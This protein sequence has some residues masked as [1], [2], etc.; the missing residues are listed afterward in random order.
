M[1]YV[2][3]KIHFCPSSKKQAER[4][5]EVGQHSFTKRPVD[6]GLGPQQRGIAPDAEDEGLVVN[7]RLDQC[8]M[9]M[10]TSPRSTYANR[11]ALLLELYDE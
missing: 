1:L 10:H 4:Q 3:T 8:R 9:P 2:R 7:S 5:L 11:Q 6:I